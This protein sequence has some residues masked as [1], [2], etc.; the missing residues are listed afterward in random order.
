[1]PRTTRYRER[2]P[3]LRD[4]VTGIA[5]RKLMADN[6]SGGGGRK[7][8]SVGIWFSLGHSTIVF[9]LA[10]LLSV[11]VKVGCSSWPAVVGQRRAAYRGL[12]RLND[13]WY[14]PGRSAPEQQSTLDETSADRRRSPVR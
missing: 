5:T 9:G 8:L 11:G 14:D 3:P 6:T 12:G 7:P 4:C 13:A 10:F 2:Q 1:M